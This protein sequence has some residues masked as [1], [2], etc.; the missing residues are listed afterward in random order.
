MMNA[1]RNVSMVLLMAIPFG[2]GAYAGPVT[3]EVSWPQ[4]GRTQRIEIPVT[5]RVVRV[6]EEVDQADAP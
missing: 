6:L 1:V 4:T 2:L 3:V 5:R